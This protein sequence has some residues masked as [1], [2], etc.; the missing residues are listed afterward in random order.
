MT[1]APRS[2]AALPIDVGETIERARAA[3]RVG[4]AD[5]AEMA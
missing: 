5:E 1:V 2:D 3:W 4:R